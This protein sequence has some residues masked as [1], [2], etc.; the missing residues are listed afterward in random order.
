MASLFG[1]G[2][3]EAMNFHW[4]FDD[5]DLAR[6]R[7]AVK[8]Y[9]GNDLVE[10]RR[11][12]NLARTKHPPTRADFWYWMVYALLTSNQRS[13]PNS[14]VVTFMNVEPFP[15][16]LRLCEPCDDLLK[17]VREELK[18][19]S[20]RFWK[21]RIP[22]FIAANIHKVKG[23][24]WK[25]IA[26]ELTRLCEDQTVKGERRAA[27]HLSSPLLAGIGPKQSRNLLQMLGLTRYETPIDIR[28]VKWLRKFGFPLPLSSAALGDHDFYEFVEDG[29]Q[30]LCRE[31]GVMPCV[32]DA[33]VFASFDAE[34]WPSQEGQ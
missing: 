31:A 13:S 12:I 29:L 17:M 1:G 34:P 3:N 15:L 25:K 9:E 24:E 26:H 21:T 19:R 5:R 16:R 33:A 23:G 7:K 14:P 30:L 8:E 18:R 6:I 11:R 27:R 2:A 4:D 22:G 28:V 20:V 32:F 10:D